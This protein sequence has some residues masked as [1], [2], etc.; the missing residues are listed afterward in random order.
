MLPALQLFHDR[1]EII[2]DRAANAAIWKIMNFDSALLARSAQQRAINR[3]FAELI[4]QDRRSG[5]FFKRPQMS[6]VLPDPRKPVTIVTGIF[7]V[8]R[9]VLVVAP[10]GSLSDE[11]L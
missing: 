6:V 11:D 1:Q 3:D 4:D 8:I 2:F 10:R 9:S 5:F 7:I